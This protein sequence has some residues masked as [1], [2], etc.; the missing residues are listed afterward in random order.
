MNDFSFQNATHLLTD[1]D[2][3]STLRARVE[4]IGA[5]LDTLA[6]LPEDRRHDAA[7]LRD[8]VL[9]RFRLMAG[10]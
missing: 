9:E 3:L 7:D 5:D 2:R 6:A 8:R 10:T 1:S 4:E